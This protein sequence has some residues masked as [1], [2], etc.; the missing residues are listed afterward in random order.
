MFNNIM[1]MLTTV[2]SGTGSQSII[3]IWSGLYYVC[4]F[5]ALLYF[6]SKYGKEF[7]KIAKRSKGSLS[8][9]KKILYSFI[10]KWTIAYILFYTSVPFI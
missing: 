4:G 5:S 8:N 7:I 9:R 1:A 6:I 10:N 3:L 2:I